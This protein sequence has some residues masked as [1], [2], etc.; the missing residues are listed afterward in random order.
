MYDLQLQY[1][2]D[3]RTEEGGS[4]KNE[5]IS[6]DVSLPMYQDTYPCICVVYVMYVFVVYRQKKLSALKKFSIWIR[7]YQ[8]RIARA[9]AHQLTTNLLFVDEYNK[10]NY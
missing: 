4:N 5:R 6:G 3:K 9:I 8:C 10:S 2:E 1:T 7:M